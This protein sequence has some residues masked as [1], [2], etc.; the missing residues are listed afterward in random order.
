MKKGFEFVY[1]ICRKLFKLNQI[2]K[3]T[4]MRSITDLA[5]EIQKRMSGFMDYL[6]GE[7]FSRPEVKNI[8]G[9][10]SGML[11]KHDV[12]VSVLSRS[13]QEKI[14]PKKPWERLSRNL[15]REGL[16]RRLAAANMKKYSGAIRKNRYCVIDLSDIQKPYAGQMEGLSRVRDG[17]KSGRDTVS[18]GNGLYWLNAVMAD[19]NDILPVY[20]EIYSLD[21]EG[22]DHVSENSKILGI[23]DMVHEIHPEAIYVHDR[24]GDRTEIIRTLYADGKTF[25]VR[26]QDQRSLRLHKDSA[27]KTNIKKIA[28]AVSLRHVYTSHRKSERFDV[29]IRRVYHDDIP[30]WLVVSRRRR[31]GLSWYLTNSEGMRTAIMDMVMEAYGLRWRIEE[32]HRQIKQDYSLEQLCLRNYAAIKNMGVLVMLAASFCARLPEHI[33]IKLLAVSHHLPRKRLRDIPKYP[34]YKI[35]AAVAYILQH[36]DKRPY[37]PLHVRKREYVQLQLGFTGF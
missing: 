8:G 35:V 22:K 31:G 9:L 13:L 1:L 37:K 26:G 15:K 16:W 12:H 30:L 7:G 28:K 3:G 14:S 20:G 27:R 2:A 24:G 4:P 33:V 6:G 17:D 19:G 32:Y 10:L 5:P 25:V 34:Y 23:T 11:K 21:R 36:T 18:I 29:G